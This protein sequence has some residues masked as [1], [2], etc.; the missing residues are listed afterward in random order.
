MTTLHVHFTLRNQQAFQRLLDASRAAASAQTNQGPALS[1]SGGRSW[2]KPSPLSAA[3]GNLANV[4]DVNAR[5]WLGRTVLHLAVSSLDPAAFEFVKLLLT[6]PKIDVNIADR[7]SHWT[8]LHRALYAGNLPASVLLLQRGDID[9]SLKDYEGYTAFDVYNSSVEGTKPSSTEATDLYTWGT[10]RNAALGVVDGDD[11]TFPE[12]VPIPPQREHAEPQKLS[13]KERFQPIRAERIDMAKLHTAVVTSEFRANLRI[14]GFGSGGRLGF[15]SAQYIQYALA[16]LKELSSEAQIVD[17]ALGQDHT[18]ALTKTGGVLSWGLARFSQLGYALDASQTMQTAPRRIV[19]PLK[20]EHVIGI[21]ACRTASACWTHNEL[22]TWGTNGG[23][24]GYDR[25]GTP[26]QVLPRRVTQITLPVVDVALSDGAMAVLLANHDAHCFHNGRTFKINFPTQSFPSEIQVYRPPMSQNNASIAKVVSCDTTFAALSSNGEVFTFNLNPPP[27]TPAA[28][29]GPSPGKNT[30]VNVRRIWALRKQFTAVKDVALGSDG[31]IVLCTESGHVYTRGRTNK[32]S[33][34]TRVPFLQ[35]AVAVAASSAGAFAV[36]KAECSPTPIYLRGNSVAEDMDRVQPY[37]SSFGEHERQVGYSSDVATPPSSG[38]HTE[39]PQSASDDASTEVDDDTEEAP[40]KRDIKVL[41]R[42]LELIKRDALA[43]RVEGNGIFEG[44]NLGHGADL[45]IKVDSGFEFPVH[46]VIFSARSRVMKGALLGQVVK[47]SDGRTRLQLAK[48]QTGSSQPV[49]RLLGT[50]PLSALMLAVYLYTDDIPAIWD[51]RVFLAISDKFVECMGKLTATDIRNELQK[52][53]T[54]LHLPALADSLSAPVKRPPAERLAADL[55]A[56]LDS[57]QNEASWNYDSS[58][59]H[60][61]APDTILELADAHMYCHSMILRARSPFFADFFDD[62]DWTIKRRRP[63]NALAVNLRHVGRRSMDFVVGYIYA[64]GNEEIFDVLDFAD[65][66]DDVVEFMFEVID[67]AGELLLDRLILICSSV[68]LHFLN[69]NNACSILSEASHFFADQLVKSIQGYLSRNIETL[70]ESRMLDDL[71]E[72]LIRQLSLF[73]R[74]LQAEKSPMS[75]TGKV[76]EK[77]LEAWKDWLVLQDIPQPIIPGRRTTPGAIRHSPKLS[78]LATGSTTRRIRRPSGEPLSSSYSPP[79]EHRLGTTPLSAPIRDAPAEVSDDIFIM[80]DVR[81][82]IPP[83][84]LPAAQGSPNV[85]PARGPQAPASGTY[86][87]WKS[88]VA[89]SKPDLRTIMAEAEGQKT[90]PASTTPPGQP[91]IIGFDAPSAGPSSSAHRT[92]QKSDTAQSSQPRAGPSSPWRIP[93]AEPVAG[94]GPSAMPGS[95]TLA[96]KPLELQTSPAPSGLTRDLRE[97]QVSGARPPVAQTPSNAPQVGLAMLG[98][99]K[100]PLGPTFTPTRQALP[101]SATPMIRKVSE[102]TAKAW[103]TLPEPTP[104]PKQAKPA[105]TTSSTS[106][107]SFLAI[108]QQQEDQKG[109]S[110]R[111]KT[112]LLEIQREEQARAAEELAIR[113]EMEFMQWWAAEEERIRRETQA[114]PGPPVAGPVGSRKGAGNRP[115]GA[116]KLGQKPKASMTFNAPKSGQP[117]GEG[118]RVDKVGEVVAGEQKM[119][120]KPKR[121]RPKA[122]LNP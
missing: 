34:F 11:R 29:T 97:H 36:L 2:N 80:D 121:A 66:A 23:Q 57:A 6:H 65:T 64:G 31:T 83:I 13:I 107:P 41:M 39:P 96:R 78:P 69:I 44:A 91:R 116:K 74:D 75:R 115:R 9:V 67:I 16:P 22:F 92:P 72:Q 3:A 104:E 84:S 37:F 77:A 87:P 30:G 61:V 1:S 110:S 42:L 45:F 21:A 20:K 90:V 95:P 93:K 119:G 27:S 111:P 48:S 52:L 120:N 86:S 46:R 118:R 88:R 114:Q 73:V 103:A 122:N 18:L 26:V 106:P 82:E 49:L 70:L 108:Q 15:G 99:G 101:V 53:A 24:L 68:I 109:G 14:C 35:R 81:D 71:S 117:G 98:K 19:G 63:N 105:G 59:A 76:V 17:V 54:L 12:L 8:P 85:G 102:G 25:T 56:L 94:S 51:R 112:S 38:G 62:P 5:D 89:S 55:R 32:T 79:I 43:R 28:D 100:A 4:C 50:H 60:P 33:K 7:E 47:D 40:I 10:N 113:E 58:G